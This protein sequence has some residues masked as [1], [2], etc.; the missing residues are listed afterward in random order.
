MEIRPTRDSDIEQVVALYKTCFNVEVRDFGYKHWYKNEENYV[1]RV[2]ELNGEIVGHNA[3][4]DREYIYRGNKIRVGLSSGGMVDSNRVKSPGLFLKMLREGISE[5]KGDVI[6]AFPNKK[7]EPF[8]IRILKFN[9]IEDGHYWVLEKEKFRGELCKFDYG[10][11]QIIRP[12]EF[13]KWRLDDHPRNEYEYL[14][15]GKVTIAIKVYNNWIELLYINQL[16]KD[17]IVLISEIF[18]RGYTRINTIST[19]SLFWKELGFVNGEYNK[20]VY[21]WKNP[22]YSN[23]VFPCSMVDSDV[24]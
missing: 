12:K 14:T 1:S 21:C 15:H 4:I 16:H 3:I 6:I 13:L 20:F 19:N 24:F 9:V 18:S 5:Y 23:D 11:E 10:N 22:I 7:A 17:I 2:C 8:W